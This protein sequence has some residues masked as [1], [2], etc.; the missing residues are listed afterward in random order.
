MDAKAQARKQA[1]RKYYLANKATRSAARHTRYIEK[2]KP[3]A[4][5]KEF[6]KILSELTV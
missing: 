6:M 1:N 3:Q 5:R 2:E 4:A